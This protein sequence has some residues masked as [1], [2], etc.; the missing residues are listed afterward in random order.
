MEPT[1]PP[2]ATAGRAPPGPRRIGAPP[3]TTGRAMT[4]GPSTLPA[5]PPPAPAARA[6]G[7]ARR[8]CG[9]V[10]DRCRLPAPHRLPGEE[11]PAPGVPRAIGGTWDLFRYPGVRSDSDMFTL[12]YQFRPWTEPRSIADGPSIR[13]YIEDTAREYGVTERIRF[14]H[15]VRS[16]GRRG[17]PLDGDGRAHRHGGDGLRVTSSSILGA[18]WRPAAGRR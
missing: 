13:R 5:A 9:P 15:R 8:G 4:P 17:R 2:G 14:H 3:A 18:S 16:A 7:R 6:R 12:G 1:A 10:R 11:L